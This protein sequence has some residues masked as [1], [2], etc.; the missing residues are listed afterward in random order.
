MTPERLAELRADLDRRR[1]CA[2]LAAPCDPDLTLLVPDSVVVEMLAEIDR[3]R[4]VATFVVGLM[5]DHE[6]ESWEGATM[7][8]GDPVALLSAVER[9]RQA[10]KGG[11]R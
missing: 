8:V 5:T 11:V 3:L 6:I 7:G 10:L 2:R 4:E 9:A 1:R